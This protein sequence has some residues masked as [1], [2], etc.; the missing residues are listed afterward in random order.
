M[1]HELIA[2]FSIQGTPMILQSDKGREF[3]ARII[4]EIMKLWWD[5]VIV[6]GCA[7]HPQSQGSVEHANQDVEEMLG[8]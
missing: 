7:R 4:V 6:H 1:V 3:V 2:I 8:N 5:V